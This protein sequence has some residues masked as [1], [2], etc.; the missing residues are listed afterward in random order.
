MFADEPPPAE[1]A[2]TK[3]IDF[4]CPYCDEPIHFSADLAGKRAP[5]PECKHIIKVPE[6]VKKDPKDWR[7]TDPR[8]PAGA[9][10]PE[11]PAPEGAWSSTGAAKVGQDT[12]VKAGVIPEKKP[13]RTLWQKARLPVIA[14]SAVLLL[15]V[16]G[17][18]GYRWW[19]L[20]AADRM[21]RQVLDYAASP[22]SAKEVGPTGQAALAMG[23]AEYY[24]KAGTS[25]SAEEA[26]KHFGKALSTLKA[27]PAG[28]DRD[29][30]LGDL[31]LA[32]IEL[33]GSGEEA[34]KG[35]RLSWEDTQKLLL[36]TLQAISD[37][38]AKREALRAVSHRLLEVGQGKMVLN[39]TNQLFSTPDAQ[40]VAALSVVGVELLRAKDQSAAEKVADDALKLY[41]GKTPPPLRPEVVA[42]A[43]ALQKKPPQAGKGAE[44]E[45][46]E[47]L[48]K[49]EGLARQ[50]KWDE[51]RQR[52]ASKELDDETRFHALLAIASA[53][54]DYRIPDH[55]DAEAAVNTAETKVRDNG[56][57]SGALLRLIRVALR[58][59]L[60]EDRLLALTGRIKD[61][62]LQGRAQ[63]VLFRDRLAQAKQ[64]VEDSEADKVRAGVSRLLA[65]EALARHNSRLDPGWAAKVQNLQ[66]PPEKAFASLGVVL[67]L[68][69]RSRK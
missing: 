37:A 65:S 56:E 57:L 6:L 7:K 35:F 12:L 58:A 43:M 60:P 8:G 2:E 13:P 50:E 31:A 68:Q 41:E 25:K 27:S 63:L 19:G 3:T 33:G 67:G 23:A 16:G 9:R 29:T 18:S 14:V 4:N 26:H 66:Q 46:N 61:R 62:S 64:G 47:T 48:G 32:E 5:C 22:E 45:H 49:I 21:F 10:L 20:R 54:V 36:S 39:L 59:G 17:W 34:Y 28:A 11:Q 53:A 69:D 44:E 40:R 52:A 38:D 1:A 30:L 51:A 15:S 55:T 42:L 24:L